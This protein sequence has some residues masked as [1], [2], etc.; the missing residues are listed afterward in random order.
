MKEDRPVLFFIF[1]ASICDFDLLPN[2]HL[3]LALQTPLSTMKGGT[4]G[5]GS[6]LSEAM[7]FVLPP[8]PCVNR[9]LC[10]SLPACGL[11]QFVCPS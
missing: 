6:S 3:S 7:P 4:P 5:I 11:P 9:K 2:L 10:H 1:L 8:L